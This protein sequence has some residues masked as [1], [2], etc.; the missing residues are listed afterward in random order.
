MKS[1]EVPVK[2][3][4]IE[5]STKYSVVAISDEGGLIYGVRRLFE[6]RSSEGLTVLIKHCLKKARLDLRDIGYFGVG[7]GPGS[8][9]GLRIG[10]SFVKGLSFA[11]KK[12]CIAFSSLDSIA[13]NPPAGLTKAS[14]E[15]AGLRVIVDARRSNVYSSLYTLSPMKKISGDTLL[16]FATFEERIAPGTIF[17]GDALHLYG[18]AIRKHGNF[19]FLPQDLWYPTPQSI[20]RLTLD[21]FKKNKSVDCFALQAS[22][23]YKEDCQVKKIC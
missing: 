3:L 2:F 10:V 12:R 4:S 21:A 1:L 9:T 15:K 6:K 18:Q 14:R 22:Y 5:T 8:F 19:K 16:P 17:A 23:L 13:F 11:L 7:C 20:A